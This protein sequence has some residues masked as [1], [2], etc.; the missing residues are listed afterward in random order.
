MDDFLAARMALL[1]ERQ[2]LARKLAVYFSGLPDAPEYIKRAL[3]AKL[4]LLK[5]DRRRAIFARFQQ[6]RQRYLHTLGISLAPGVTTCACTGY[7]LCAETYCQEC[8][9]FRRM[10]RARVKDAQGQ[11]LSARQAQNPWEYPVTRIYPMPRCPINKRHIE[12][13]MQSWQENALKILED[14]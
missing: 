9:D 1:S 13:E 2:K 14:G 11:Y 10:L 5:L 7:K 3:D 6:L 4:P 8:R 12:D